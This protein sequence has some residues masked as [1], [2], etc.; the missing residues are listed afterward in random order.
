MVE[1]LLLRTTSQLLT[2]SKTVVLVMH[3]KKSEDGDIMPAMY[4]KTLVDAIIG[5]VKVN[6]RLSINSNGERVLTVTPKS[7]V[8]AGNRI[9]LKDAIATDYN[10]LMS[11]LTTE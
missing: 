4:R 11:Q 10:G 1:D 8:V 2:T 3:E 6:A 9:G 7:N 5:L